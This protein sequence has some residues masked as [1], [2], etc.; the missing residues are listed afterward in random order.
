MVMARG[1]NQGILSGS[2]INRIKI[3][4]LAVA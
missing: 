2:D 1:K 4:Q 3:M